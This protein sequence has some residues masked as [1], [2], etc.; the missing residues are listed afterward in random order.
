MEKEYKLT[1]ITI[2]MG[3]IP[4]LPIKQSKSILHVTEDTHV[5]TEKRYN[6]LQKF[7]MR[8]FFNIEVEDVRKDKRELNN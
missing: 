8:Y 5:Y 6:A 4:R 7:C 2:T 1:D 3:E